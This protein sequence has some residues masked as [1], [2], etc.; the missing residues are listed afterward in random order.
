VNTT[1]GLVFDPEVKGRIWAVMSGIHDL[2]R[3]KMWRGRGVAHYN[4]GVVTSEDGG[5]A[6]AVSNAGINEAAVTHIVLDPTSPVGKRTLYVCAFGKGVYKSTDNGT[7]WTLKNNGIKG[8]EPFA[9]ALTLADDRTLYLVVARRSEDGSIGTQNDGALYR[10]ADGAEHWEEITLPAGCNG[11]TS[12]AI[13]PNDQRRLILSAWGRVAGIGGD[14]GG[15]IYISE[16]SGDTWRQVLD[17]D[18]HI[19]EVTIDQR[20]DVYYACG[21]ES[22]AFRT[23]DRGKTWTRIKGFNF[24]WGRRVIPDPKNPENIFITTFG[25]SVWYGPA[26]GDP[27]APEDITTPVMAY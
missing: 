18:Q 9:W 14:T 22:S 27:K 8:K 16:D 12:L 7:T 5:K 19:H 21:F 24:K 2:P 1:Y 10:S 6:W 11:P 15:G 25:G 26:A 17:K 13:D 23:T 20:N 4:G 3:P